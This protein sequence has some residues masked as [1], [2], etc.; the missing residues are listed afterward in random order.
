MRAIKDGDDATV[1]RAVLDL[2]Q[3]RRLLAPLALVVGAFVMLFEGVKL[4]FSNWRLTLVEVLPAMWIW[5]A[6]FDLKVHLLHGKSFYVLRGPV[7]I[8]I[9][10]A[11]AAITAAAF[12]LN[13]VFAFAVARPGTPEIKRGF[14]DAR[15]HLLVVVSWGFTIG[16]CLGIATTV[17]PALGSLVVCRGAEPRRWSDDGGLRLGT[18]AAPR[19]EGDPLQT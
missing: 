16:L 18:V 13:A 2:S 3:R 6:M 19:G 8:P 14:V 11:I 12:Y 7:L 5:L 15:S 1:E 9:I 17:L 10:L 4:L